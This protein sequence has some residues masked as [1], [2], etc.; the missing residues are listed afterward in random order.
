M[1][2]LNEE[3]Q[4]EDEGEDNDGDNNNARIPFVVTVSKKDGPSLE[5]SCTAFHDGIG[6]DSLSF[7]NPNPE[8][9]ELAYEGPDFK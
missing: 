4:D 6:I 9:D 2:D 1:L 3:E 8:D 5:F 7:R